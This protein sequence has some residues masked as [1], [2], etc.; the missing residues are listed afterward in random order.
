MW[1]IL[2]MN[3]NDTFLKTQIIF[4]S[5]FIAWPKLF[6]HICS[7]QNMLHLHTTSSR[8]CPCPKHVSLSLQL[9]SLKIFFICQFICDG[10]SRKIDFIFLYVEKESWLSASSLLSDFISLFVKYREIYWEKI[11]HVSLVDHIYSSKGLN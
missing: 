11:I 10:K 6:F 3:H 4:V 8:W 1:K 9:W 2:Q 7:N 5:P